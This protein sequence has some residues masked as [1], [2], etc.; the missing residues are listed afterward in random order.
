MR[1]P[2]FQVILKVDDNS[3]SCSET[4]DSNVV[5]NL[6]GTVTTEEVSTPIHLQ[7]REYF[8]RIL[9]SKKKSDGKSVDK[10]KVKPSFYG[11]ALTTDKVFERLE[12]EVTE[13]EEKK[14]ALAAKQKKKENTKKEK[15]QA[16]ATKQK[17]RATKKKATTSG[18]KSSGV[19]R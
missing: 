19:G 14:Q 18:G 13:K 5:I 3:S 12:K 1:N 15:K 8:A 2:F 4:Q 10:R 11:E 16:L 7:L 17:K 9:A 6:Q